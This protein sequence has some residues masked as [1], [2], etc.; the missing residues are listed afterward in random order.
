M[1]PLPF[2]SAA[3]LRVD[4]A[5]AV[6]L[7]IDVQVRL[8]AAMDAGALA[9]CE[10]NILTLIELGRRL[11]L[12]LVVS[13][14]YP[15]GLGPTVPA[16]AGALEAAASAGSRLLRLEKTAFACTEEPGFAPLLEQ[17]AERRQW[18]VTGME[19][20][21][22]VWQTVRGLRALGRSVQVIEDAVL[23]RTAANHRVGLSLCERV[24][25]VLTSTEAVAFDALVRAGSEDFK[26]ISRLVK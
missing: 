9:G 15:R 4:P 8:A 25:A 13:E 2:S 16:I 5:G 10:R 14:Q 23:S 12:P 1:N 6:L 17:L 18:L 26:A 20:H 11:R 22:C 7:I 24:G 21:V 19:S 3:D